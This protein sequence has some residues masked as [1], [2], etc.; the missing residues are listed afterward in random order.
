MNAGDLIHRLTVQ[1]STEASDGHDGIVQ[2]WADSDRRRI[3]GKVAPLQGHD[4]ERARQ[5]DPRAS[6]EVT[7]RF[8]SAYATDLD[9]GRARLVFHDG[10]VGD[11][12]FEIVEAPREIEHRVALAM[13]C[14]E[15]Q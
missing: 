1:A 5:I 7:L 12:T 15:A 4:L 3:A 9:G 13:V 8:W 11:R 6:H 10:G 14:K 2:T